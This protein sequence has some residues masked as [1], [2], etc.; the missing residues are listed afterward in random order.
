MEAPEPIVVVR[1]PSV[2]MSVIVPVCV[3]ASVPKCVLPSTPCVKEAPRVKGA[4]CAREMAHVSERP[5]VRDSV[6]EVA[7]REGDDGGHAG[8]RS[9][10]SEWK[11]PGMLCERRDTQECVGRMSMATERHGPSSGRSY[12]ENRAGFARRRVRGSCRAAHEAAASSAA[13]VKPGP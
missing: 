4:T 11:C 9:R 10:V 8:A 13:R 2:V 12:F 1:I 6:C 5:C 3:V 7:V